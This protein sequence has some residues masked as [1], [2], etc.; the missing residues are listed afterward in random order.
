MAALRS[1]AVTLGDLLREEKANISGILSN[2]NT[3]T[4]D[5]SEITS[6]QGD[7]IA[8]AITRLN[9][10]MASLETTMAS[11]SSTTGQLDKILAR[12]DG[13]EGTLGKLIN[14]PDLYNRL[15][16]LVVGVDELLSDF[17]RNPRRYL[18]EMKIVDLF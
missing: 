6:Q 4:G 16:S 1:S 9:S 5:L 12:I 8:L 13:G 2:V 15:D 3:V 7:S 18:R 10:A 14:D 17:K 11:L